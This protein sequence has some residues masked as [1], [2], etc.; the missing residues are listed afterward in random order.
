M[1]S[2]SESTQSNR[3]KETNGNWLRIFACDRRSLALMRILLGLLILADLG[4]R[5]S[6]MEA[7]YTDAGFFTVADWSKHVDGMS[8]TTA[9]ISWSLHALSGSTSWQLVLFAIAAIAAV[10][11]TVGWKTRLACIVS[12]VL[13]TSLQMRN[14]LI[15]HSGDC[16]FR[17]AIFWGIFLPWG[18]MFSIDSRLRAKKTAKSDSS[19]ANARRDMANPVISGATCGLILSLFSMYS[20]AGISKL[21]SNWYSGEAL[22]C[23]LKLDIYTTSIGSYALQYPTLLKLMTWGTMGVEIVLPIMMLI[24]WRNQRW[25]WL[26]MFAFVSLHLS[27]AACMSIGLFSWVAIAVWTSLISGAFWDRIGLRLPLTNTDSAA[28]EPRTRR[29][30]AGP[31]GL[32]N[33]VCLGLAAYF[34]VWNIA[35]INHP[36]LKKLMPQEA[37]VVGKWLNLRQEFRM[38]DVPPRH[39]PWFVYE[40]RL[41]NGAT[42]D[43]F[44]QQPVDHSRP[45]SVKATIP[46]HHWRRLHRNLARPHLK[47][48][49]QPVS[50]YMIRRWNDSHDED[51]QV[52]VATTTA[53]L[54]EIVAGQESQSLVSQVWYVH[55]GELAE[56]HLFD[57]LLKQINEKGVI[58][59]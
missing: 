1:K 38:F 29:W 43:I 30:F 47:K 53:Y 49:R 11:M 7:M 42:I 45:K 33:V 15:L 21:N 52:E 31:S 36:Q 55:G 27:I 6:S 50:E 48:F 22:E 39:S 3:V 19:H 28:N 44:R 54:E 32:V 57:D 46:Q 13:L 26:A 40:A 35:T 17:L 9:P 25:R 23:V 16:L 58:L 4:M 14:P 5:M 37:R 20:F 2:E 59:P 56:K 34:M 18:S 12:W 10:M 8:G 51:S 41:K 24:P